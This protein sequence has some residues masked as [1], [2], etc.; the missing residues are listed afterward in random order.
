MASAERITIGL[1][2]KTVWEVDGGDK[3]PAKNFKIRCVP[4]AI[5]ICQP[6]GAA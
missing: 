4:G 5:R 6:S 1:K 3:T 2:K